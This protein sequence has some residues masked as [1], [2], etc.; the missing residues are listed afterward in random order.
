MNGLLFNSCL[1]VCTASEPTDVKG[2]PTTVV[3]T[4]KDREVGDLSFYELENWD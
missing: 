1:C 2:N 3:A 4:A